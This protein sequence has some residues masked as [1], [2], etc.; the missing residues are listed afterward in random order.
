MYIYD[1][2]SSMQLHALFFFRSEKITNKKKQ[3]SPKFITLLIFKV[4]LVANLQYALLLR[5]K[6]IYP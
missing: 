6:N 4:N 3:T 2:S 1:S 5:K